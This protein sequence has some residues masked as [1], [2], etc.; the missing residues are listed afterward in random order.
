MT[1]FPKKSTMIPDGMSESKRAEFEAW[2]MPNTKTITLISK[3]K[4]WHTVQ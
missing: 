3:M 1:K 2:Y 4:Y